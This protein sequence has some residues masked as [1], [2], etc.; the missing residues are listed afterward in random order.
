MLVL[1]TDVPE[2][3]ELQREAGGGKG[4]DADTEVSRVGHELTEKR[5]H[6][7]QLR[8]RVKSLT[9]NLTRFR[10][11]YKDLELE[12]K[13]VNDEDSPLTRKVHH[14][15]KSQSHGSCSTTHHYNN[16]NNNETQI[17][18]LENRLDKAMIKYNE[19]QSIR[20]TYEQIVKRLREERVGFDNQ[21]AALERT[22]NAKRHDY[23]ELLLLSGDANHAKEMA[24]SEQRASERESERT[25]TRGSPRQLPPPHC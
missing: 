15:A 16:E 6:Y 17:R 4:R 11:K 19:A 12:A 20:K 7:D 23:E 10:D 3:T 18:L 21:L 9:E 25:A 1:T 2:H 8:H 13:Q 22:L 5:T 24:V 14:N